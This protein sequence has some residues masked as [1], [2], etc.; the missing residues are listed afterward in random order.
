MYIWIIIEKKINC[1]NSNLTTTP[2]NLKIGV[3]TIIAL[4]THTTPTYPPHTLLLLEI[5]ELVDHYFYHFFSYNGSSNEKV[6]FAKD[7][8]SE[9]KS[10]NQVFPAP[11]RG[12]GGGGQEFFF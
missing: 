8:Q 4:H 9:L 1:Q 6:F 10:R 12:G 5:R 7:A 11:P 2:P 3:D